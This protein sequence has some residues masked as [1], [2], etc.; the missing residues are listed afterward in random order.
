MFG[1]L[2]IVFPMHHEGGALCLRR[3]GRE[4]IFDPGQ[5]LAGGALDRPSI[6]YVAFLNN[7]K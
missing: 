7:I 5:A 4:W 1:S 6:G 2:V 3:R